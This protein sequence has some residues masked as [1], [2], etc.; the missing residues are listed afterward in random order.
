[1]HRINENEKE[2]RQS[3]LEEVNQFAVAEFTESLKVFTAYMSGIRSYL[4]NAEEFP[5]Q[6]ELFK[7]A[8]FH[9]KDLDKSDSLILSYLS[10]DHKFIYSFNRNLINPNGL[11]GMMI[12]ELRDQSEIDRLNLMVKDEEFHLFPPI[13]LIEG[14]A[15][16]PL[17]FNL[18]RGDKS[19]GYIASIVSTGSLIAPIYQNNIVNEMIFTFQVGDIYF[20][21]E[22]V[23]DTVNENNKYDSLPLTMFHQS[24]NEFIYSD[25]NLY[26]Q[27]F[28][29][30][31]AYKV[32]EAGNNNIA[33]LIYG[34]FA[35][36]FLFSLSAFYRINKYRKLN[37][38]L[39]LT[40]ESLNYQH[41][42]LVK[43]NDELIE[44]NQLKDKIFSIVGHDLKAP[45]SSVHSV[46]ELM[47][48]KTLSS[49]EC[50]NMM[51]ILEPVVSNASELLERLLKWSMIN[52]NKIQIN[53]ESLSLYRVCLEV[54][55]LLKANANQKSLEIRL[56]IPKDLNVFADH[57]MLA[58]MVRNI[59]GNAIKF[60]R[61][62][63]QI[64][65][66]AR[67][68]GSKQVLLSIS[69]NGV[70]MTSQHQSQIFEIENSKIKVGTDGEKGSGLGLVMV[71]EFAGYNHIDIEVISA[72]HLGTTFNLTIPT[73]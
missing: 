72:E 34:W 31:T 5:T 11:V 38:S 36:I 2:N 13:N 59:V 51:T 25:F 56:D 71:K 21:Q 24:D 50:M 49:N 73:G 44:S 41:K 57:N 8:Q 30:G 1:M 54:K 64:R 23:Y 29:I 60:S 19:I 39:D 28:R 48:N 53:H 55:E 47:Q 45:L 4:K 40:V 58:F 7:Y 26:G 17:N 14:W 37:K 65:L 69:D 32:I 27:A 20:D 68:D 42:L 22:M 10:L 18:R 16:L 35:M 52:T 6:E 3:K 63:E 70:G 12:K 46:M 33:F 9:L 62:N 15:G 66:K 61:E 67:M 43:K